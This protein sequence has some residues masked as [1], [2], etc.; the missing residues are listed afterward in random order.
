MPFKDVMIDR[1]SVGSVEMSQE[2]DPAERR[3]EQ[4]LFGMAALVECFRGYHPYG[5][6]PR[7]RLLR[8]LRALAST[9]TGRVR[10]RALEVEIFNLFK[11]HFGEAVLDRMREGKMD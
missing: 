10:D 4:V 11:A 9:L 2:R 5:A 8:A 6:L 1:R 3:R 7:E